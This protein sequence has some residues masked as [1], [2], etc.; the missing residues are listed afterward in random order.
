MG[1]GFKT[2]AAADML[3]PLFMFILSS[4]MAICLSCLVSSSTDKVDLSN[5]VPS[6]VSRSAGETTD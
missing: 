6:P 2:A 5:S 1:V 3:A 4:D